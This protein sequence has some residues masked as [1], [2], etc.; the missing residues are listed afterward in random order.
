MKTKLSTIKKDNFYIVT[1]R[2]KYCF[3]TFKVKLAIPVKIVKTSK[4][5]DEDPPGEEEYNT[6]N[7]QIP[8]WNP[9]SAGDTGDDGL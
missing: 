2:K 5:G 8:I 3:F 7:P 1:V 9:I 4:S 6:A